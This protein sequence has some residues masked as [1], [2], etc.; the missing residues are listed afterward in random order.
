MNEA[1]VHLMLNHVPVIG[2]FVLAFI[3]IHLHIRNNEKSKK[4][5]FLSY[6]LVLAVMIVVVITGDPSE[7]ILKNYPGISSSLIELH[8]N[9]GYA[10][11]YLII[12]LSLLSIYGLY[13]IR[14]LKALPVWF[15]T[16]FIT[17][18]SVLIVLVAL[19]AHY[20]GQIRHPE[21]L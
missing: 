14:K 13:L 4:G 6:I 12:V 3:F 20:G 2:S 18:A 1:Q 8:E 21:I 19:T 11:L 5:V 10:S 17:A 7:E 9:F 15:N 16:G